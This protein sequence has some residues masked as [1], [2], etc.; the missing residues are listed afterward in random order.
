[1]RGLVASRYIV[2][3]LRTLGNAASPSGSRPIVLFATTLLAP[4]SSS[5]PLRP[6]PEITFPWM[7]ELL[8]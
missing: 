5:T 3:P 8:M 2:M 6:L 7:R 1:M 4:P